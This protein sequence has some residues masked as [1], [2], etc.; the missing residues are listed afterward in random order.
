MT[1]PSPQPV[2]DQ[3]PAPAPGLLS[4]SEILQIARDC[5]ADDCGLVSIEHP[6]LAPERASV[7]AA[8]PATR[9]LLALVGRMNREPVRSPARSISNLEFHRTGHAMD[10][11]ARA[12]VR[13]LED[14]ACAR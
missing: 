8:F 3:R 10:D 4:S 5:G 6:T 12:I 2:L 1:L 7:L 13:R 11:I 14:R 9:S